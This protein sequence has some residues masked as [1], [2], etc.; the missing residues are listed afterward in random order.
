MSLREP[1]QGATENR[2]TVTIGNRRG[3]YGAEITAGGL[4]LRE[5]RIA[6]GLLLNGV[7]DAGWVA[8]IRDKNVLQARLAITGRWS[9][10]V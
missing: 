7:D 9:T 3:R 4:K 1:Q 2:T 10:L 8:A 6:A 5:S